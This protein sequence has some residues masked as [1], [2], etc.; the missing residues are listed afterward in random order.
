MDAQV[1]SIDGKKMGST[2]LPN[3][4]SERI[5]PELIRRAVDAENS[6]RL[7]PQGHYPLAGMQTTATYYGAMHS[8]RTGRHMG[9]AIRPR[10]KLGGGAQGKVRRIPS[11]VTGKRAHPHVIEKRL[12]ENINKKEYRLAVASAIAATAQNRSPIVAS[13]EIDNIAKTKDMLHAIELVCGAKLE[14]NKAKLRKGLRRSSRRRIYKKS[15]LVVIGQ[16]SAA[17]RSAKNI[18]GVDAC[19][20]NNLSVGLLAP[21]GSPRKM[22]IWSESALKSLDGAIEKLEIR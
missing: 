4:F 9:V 11:S 3:V 15:V 8:Y 2:A 21:G 1:I 16:P 13:K 19:T 18:A 7:Q 20:I 22:V 14:P 10:E 17:T 12:I 5:R 6:R